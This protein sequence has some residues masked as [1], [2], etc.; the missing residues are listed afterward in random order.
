MYLQP[1]ISDKFLISYQNSI[2]V[3]DIITTVYSQRIISLFTCKNMII[4]NK[5]RFQQQWT[6]IN[7]YENRLNFRQQIRKNSEKNVNNLA[8][9]RINKSRNVPELCKL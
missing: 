7:N 5:K 6:L 9:V 1:I 4:R 3:N 8:I 2:F